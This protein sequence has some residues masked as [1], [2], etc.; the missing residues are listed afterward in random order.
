MSKRA[1]RVHPAAAAP[2]SAALRDAST[3]TASKRQ[4][5]VLYMCAACKML[6]LLL[7]MLLIGSIM[8]CL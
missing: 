2:D 3:A 6:L 8:A 4:A 1:H 7:L 5:Q